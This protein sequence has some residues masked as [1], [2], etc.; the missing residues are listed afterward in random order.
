MKNIVL[1]L[2]VSLLSGCVAA[3]N[4]PSSERLKVIMAIRDIFEGTDKQDWSKVQ[5]AFA[6]KVFLDYSSLSGKPASTLNSTEIIES[7]KKVIPGFDSTHH[8]LARFQVVIKDNKAKVHY[9]GKADHILGNETWIVEGVYDT[10]LEKTGEQWK[11]TRHK[12]SLDQQRGD[13]TLAAKAM[14]RIK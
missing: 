10:T 14:E 6:P 9:F 11:V 2:T 12:F 8:Q 7:W 3:Q 4:P 5:S 13:L 1:L